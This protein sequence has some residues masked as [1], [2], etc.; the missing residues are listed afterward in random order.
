MTGK[1]ERF[2]RCAVTV[3]VGSFGAALPAQASTIVWT[4]WSSASAGSPGTASG[5]IASSPSL[6]VSYSGQNSGLL[7]NYPSWTP[8]GTFSGGTV[9]NT[10]PQSFNAI[11]LTGGVT[12][13]NTLTFSSAITDPVLAIWSLGAPGNQ[14]SFDFT[15]AEPFT[16]EAGGPSAEYGGSSITVSGND[17]LG[18]EGNGVIQFNGTYSSLTWTN[19]TFESYYAFTV[20]IAG[21]ASSPIPE[22]AAL[23]LIGVGLCALAYLRRTRSR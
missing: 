5:T 17:V 7:A 9:G 16:L 6:T 21:V 19:P 11:A 14:A 10:P 18:A 1:C 8:T 3:I 12:T 20:G 22:P 15:A 4:D 23:G 13:T 2:I